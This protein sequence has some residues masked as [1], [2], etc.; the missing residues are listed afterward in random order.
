MQMCNIIQEGQ[1]YVTLREPLEARKLPIGPFYVFW[2]NI[3]GHFVVMN[4][5]RGPMPLH[6]D[7]AF[8][9]PTTTAENCVVADVT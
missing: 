2:C 8:E 5:F 3:P 9:E 7:F 1:R 6:I 4:E